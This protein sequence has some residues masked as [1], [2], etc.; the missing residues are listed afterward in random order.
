MR[1]RRAR[2]VRPGHIEQHRAATA[3]D[4]GMAAN[5]N[6]DVAV[7]PLPSEPL[8][9][10]AGGEELG[11]AVDDLTSDLDEL[12]F[13]CRAAEERLAGLEA[14]LSDACPHPPTRELLGR[15]VASARRRYRALNG[16]IRVL[17]GEAQCVPRSRSLV[18]RVTAERSSLA[19]RLRVEQALMAGLLAAPDWQS[20]SFLHS[21]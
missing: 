17:Q 12:S 21:R 14:A 19:D 20:P 6:G 11:C 3:G 7:V 15:A 2:P 10:D 9:H 8:V 18:E 5:R 13:L 4:S 1:S 16:R